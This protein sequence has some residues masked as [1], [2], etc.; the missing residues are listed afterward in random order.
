M[1]R[2]SNILKNLCGKLK[3][4]GG[5][6]TMVVGGWHFFIFIF[7]L[8]AVMATDTVFGNSSLGNLFL[9]KV[10]PDTSKH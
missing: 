2:S 3:G 9:K 1:G 4:G 8:L 7:S 10:V 6:N 5:G